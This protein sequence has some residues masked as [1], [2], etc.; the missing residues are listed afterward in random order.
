MTE[1]FPEK[2]ASSLTRTALFGILCPMDATVERDGQCFCCGADNDKGLHLTITYPEKGS[3]E[4]SL[5]VPRISP[6]GRR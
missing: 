2:P 1:G 3:A 6:G 5:E 4:T